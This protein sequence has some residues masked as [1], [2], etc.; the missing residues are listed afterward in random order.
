MAETTHTGDNKR[1]ARNTALM[2]VRYVLVLFINLY[3]TRAI[4][5][6]LGVLD[7]GIY[8]VV[9]G[10]VALLG[11]LNI[12]MT[13]G[14]QRF[15]NVAIGQKK[16][17]DIGIIYTN[18]LLI[19]AMMAGLLL[20]GAETIGWWY[21]ENKLVL[22]AERHTTAMWVYQLAVT[23]FALVIMQGPY[24]GIIMAKERMD[25]IAL[26]SI[27]DAVLK[28]LI[29]VVLPYFSGDR[30][31]WYGILLC[32]V[33]AIDLLLYIIYAKWH[34]SEIKLTSLGKNSYLRAILSFSGW[35]I[36]GS[37]AYM[38]REQ[39]LNVLMNLFYGPIV[40]AARGVAVQVNGGIQSFISNLTTAIRPQLI[41]SYAAGETE[42]T[43]QLSFSMS[44][45]TCAVVYLMAVPIM[46]EID[47]IL[48]WWL[49]GNVPEHTA[50][51]L[52][53]IIL[54]SIVS[55]LNYAVSSVIHATGRMMVYQVVTSVI[56]LLGIPAA[57]AAM[58]MGCTPEEGMW[59]MW[60]FMCLMQ[61]ASVAILK[62]IVPQLSVASYCL[63]IVVRLAAMAA[64]TLP[65]IYL[66]RSLMPD[67]WLRLLVV[68]AASVIIIL[69]AMYIILAD[70]REKELINS[71]F[72][73][74]K[75]KTKTKQ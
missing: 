43:L 38:M 14:I 8:N 70:R 11:F 35:N 69:P 32:A 66:I 47:F 25:F 51:F 10:F 41:Q 50:G 4:L 48:D 56:A 1:I 33:S 27:L 22:P 20:L 52:L 54:I 26:V 59:I 44:K 30:L 21:V 18:A 61:A 74:T 24:S 67:G 65:L 13:N 15:Y 62:H 29:V 28:L 2:T 9:A 39:G 31:I 73:K 12:S 36:F 64:I 6:A 55:N 71:F 63:N 40:N 7:F 19:Q 5:D 72:T 16:P 45:M 42:R 75:T 60:L 49:K 57:Y 46:M 17:E 58:R 37:F 34:F 68:G 53:V 23:S 3:I